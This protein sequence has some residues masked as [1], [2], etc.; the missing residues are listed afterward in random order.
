MR[1]CFV[2]PEVF[3]WGYHGGFGFLTRTLGRE[4]ANRGH[5]VSVVTVRRKGQGEIEELEGMKVYGF[6]GFKVGPRAIRAV[7][8]RIKS[9][10]YYRR[11]E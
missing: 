2:S 10:E 11:A 6:P 5:E 3:A 4:L 7:A 1:I 9:I 8:S